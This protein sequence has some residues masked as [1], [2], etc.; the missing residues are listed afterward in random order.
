MRLEAILPEIYTFIDFTT[1]EYYKAKRKGEH[2]FSTHLGGEMPE[3][4]PMPYNVYIPV[5]DYLKR[6]PEEIDEV[7]DYLSEEFNKK[8]YSFKSVSVTE[9]EYIERKGIFKKCYPQIDVT[10]EW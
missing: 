1:H 8:E 2:S 10:L 9:N 5:R 7:I 3:E 4:H 6:N